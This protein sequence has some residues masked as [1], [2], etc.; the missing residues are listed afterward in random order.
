MFSRQVRFD[1]MQAYFDCISFGL[2]RFVSDEKV[3]VLDAPGQPPRGLV[4]DFGSF[5]DGDGRRHDELWLLVAGIPEL[6]IAVNSTE[7]Q[8]VV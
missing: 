2:H 5:F 1:L 7:G 4:A 3:E 8:G 6:R